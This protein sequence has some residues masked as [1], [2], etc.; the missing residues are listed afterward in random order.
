M[1]RFVLGLNQLQAGQEKALPPT[2]ARLRPD[3]RLLEHGRTA[4]VGPPTH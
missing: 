3:L 1:T 2:D 4:Q